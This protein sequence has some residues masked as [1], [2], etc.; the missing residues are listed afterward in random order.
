MQRHTLKLCSSLSFNAVLHL[1]FA[2]R[3]ENAMTDDRKARL[4]A[5]KARAGRKP[6][7]ENAAPSVA[8]RNYTPADPALESSTEEP[9]PKKLK[10]ALQEAL[11]K[12][13]SEATMVQQD[14]TALAPK[15]INWDLKRDIQGKMDKLEKRT[16]K[17]IVE[18]L[19]ERLEQ[20][21]DLD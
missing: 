14:P 20:E 7:E 8:F 9:A 2:R 13:Q 11:E 3:S 18:L 6:E 21:A 16:Q 17:A 4:A 10:S 12:A 1:D 19:R 15:K 5:L